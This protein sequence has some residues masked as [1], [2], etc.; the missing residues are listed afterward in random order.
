MK[1]I[2]KKFDTKKIEKVL[3]K[4]GFVQFMFGGSL[5]SL[6][7]MEEGLGREK[8]FLKRS[9]SIIR[10]HRCIEGLL[11]SATDFIKSRTTLKMFVPQEQWKQVS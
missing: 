10:K 9:G 11:E 1:T 4:G 7:M 5:M 3:I 2:S 8:F 6:I